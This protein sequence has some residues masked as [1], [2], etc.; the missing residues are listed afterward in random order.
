[1]SKRSDDRLN[2]VSEV[3]MAAKDKEAALAKLKKGMSHHYQPAIK[4]VESILNGDYEAISKN[5]NSLW[6]VIYQLSQPS[7]QPADSYF[8][9]Y[10]LLSQ[11]QVRLTSA[12]KSNLIGY[13]YFCVLVFVFITYYL[14]LNNQILPTFQSFFNDF[15][16]ELPTVT[17]LV[18][19]GWFS[20]FIVFVFIL[21]F[22][23]AIII[24]WRYRKALAAMRPIPTY[25]RILPMYYRCTK[26]YNYY[27]WLSYSD[28]YAHVDE[29]KPLELAKLSLPNFKCD[30]NEMA[31]LQTAY[32]MGGFNQI[33]LSKRSRLINDIIFR[34]KVSEGIIAALAI[35]LYALL[36][37]IP[38]IAM[39]APIFMLGKVVG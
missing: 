28:I 34:I 3:A 35:V 19:S 39:Y 8:K 6:H 26:L 14:N 23:L 27:L 13:G 2:E 1:M 7:N 17:Q 33:L 16:A 12:Y 24:P 30:E 29:G 38:V 37:A 22:L 25:L 20:I 15:G 11:S 31:L 18:M 21:V 36:V 9:Q 32:E 10:N 5:K 4:T